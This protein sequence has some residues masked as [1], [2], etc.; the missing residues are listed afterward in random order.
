[1]RHKMKPSAGPSEDTSALSREAAEKTPGYKEKN[2]VK[3]ASDMCK[4]NSNEDGKNEEREETSNG[5][6]KGQKRGAKGSPNG[7]RRCQKG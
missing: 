1:M 7:T 2:I 4:K 3:S 5:G 6:K